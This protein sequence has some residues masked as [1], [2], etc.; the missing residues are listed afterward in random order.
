MR[1][2]QD[3]EHRFEGFWRDTPGKCRIRIFIDDEKNRTIGVCSAL[4]GNLGTST[5][6][7]IEY[8][9]A[10][11]KEK[12]FSASPKNSLNEVATVSKIQEFIADHKTSKPWAIAASLI[13][14]GWNFLKE[15]N[16]NEDNLKPTDEKHLIWID[17]WPKGI[18]LR[19]WE[20]EFALVKF[21]SNLEPVWYH[22][23]EEQFV[24]ESCIDLR[25]LEPLSLVEA[26][27]V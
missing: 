25:W 18:G 27:D 12:F 10:D 9:Y 4:P 23:T 11:I 19:K 13:L 21:T 15:I 16:K 2:E 22:M 24:Q 7:R 5:T 17:H 1:L 26:E 6:N 8:I 3:F 20:H 14:K